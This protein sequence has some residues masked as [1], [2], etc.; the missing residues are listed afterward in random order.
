[1]GKFMLTIALSRSQRF[2]I[3]TQ[4]QMGMGYSSA[5]QTESHVVQVHQID[6]ESGTFQI[7]H[8]FQFKVLPQHFI[9]IE[10]M[11]VV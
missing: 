11:M 2:L 8:V 6:L 3:Q 1:M 7:S 4:L 9:E 5:S 10:E